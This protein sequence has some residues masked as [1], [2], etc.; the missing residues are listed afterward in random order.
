MVSGI[1]YGYDPYN[2]YYQYPSYSSP[3][4][5]YFN[6][7]QP[8]LTGGVT[9]TSDAFTATAK[10]DNTADGKDDG[11]IGF[12]GAT[13]NLAKG[14]WN[15]VTSPFKNE[16][17]E[18]SLGSTLKSLAIGAAFVAGNIATGGALTPILLAAGV[19]FGTVSA[20][21]AG[22]NIATAETDAQAEAAWQS[23]GSSATA[24]ATS[25]FGARSYAKANGV[26]VKGFKGTKDAVVKT[27]KDAGSSI[28]DGKTYLFGQKA[29]A[30][31][32]NA[33]GTVKTP[34]RAEV[35]GKVQQK[36]GQVK[37]NYNN[38]SKD[39]WYGKTGEVISKEYAAAVEKGKSVIA[40]NS[41]IYKSA[42]E[43]G[44]KFSDMTTRQK[45]AVVKQLRNSIA[46]AAKKQIG[47]DKN[48]TLLDN[49]K[50][51]ATNPQNIG[52][53]NALVSNT[54]K[55]NFYDSL[56]KEEQA[57]FNA[58]PK[59]QREQFEDYFYSMV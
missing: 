59:A 46:A 17:G 48:A 43:S 11:S 33:D 14:A 3:E 38:S 55:P 10:K 19:T 37:D 41:S 52:I 26:D 58:L 4:M 1:N 12:W 20:V 35:T 45:A 36:W 32:L 47:Y 57:Y 49:A 50:A 27:F 21:K 5:T 23:M 7:Q 54:V 44:I 6:Y 29:K 56:S 2:Q 16:R 22:Y 15:F 39:N 30:E 25:V 34:A 31:V 13:K 40:D 53:H 18:W 8:I 24:V 9:K 42:T 28:K 51:I